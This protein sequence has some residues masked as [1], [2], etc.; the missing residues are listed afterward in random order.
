M[1]NNDITISDWH[2]PA[3]LSFTMRSISPFTLAGLAARVLCKKQTALPSLEVRLD[4]DH[5][6]VIK[7]TITSHAAETIQLYIPGS[8]LDDRPIRKVN[9]S[10]GGTL[11]AQ[12]AAGLGADIMTDREAHFIGRET[13][14]DG[15]KIHRSRTP[16]QS[17]SE[18]ELVET[19]F[20]IAELYDVSK[21]GKYKI[22]ASGSF[23]ARGTH[24]RTSWPVYFVTN[25]LEV[26]LHRGVSGVDTNSH[27]K[28]AEFSSSCIE[29]KLRAVIAVLHNCVNFALNAQRAAEWGPSSRMEVFFGKS[30]QK[31]RQHVTKVFAR[32]E[33]AC[34]N[35]CSDLPHID[36][37]DTLHY[38]SKQTLGYS[39]SSGLWLCDAFFK[40]PGRTRALWNDDQLGVVFHEIAH[41]ENP[42]IDDY[43]YATAVLSLSSAKALTNADNYLYFARSAAYL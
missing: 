21:R 41:V 5:G 34:Q 32:I 36:C 27:I 39:N 33:G 38:C 1:N 13:E 43:G 42:R 35:V 18:G 9:V 40:L 11:F 37:V 19:V 2:R 6:S 30:D 25:T 3:A 16:F 8:L 24:D 12:F 4:R 31:T 20:D 7:A 15:G 23:L 17:L 28:R 29:G 10:D 14:A 26:E 22:E